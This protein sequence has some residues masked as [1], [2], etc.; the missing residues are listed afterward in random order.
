MIRD[1]EVI[2]ELDCKLK[3][4]GELGQF[5]AKFIDFL[6]VDFIPK[7][8]FEH[9]LF[10]PFAADVS[11]H[12]IEILADFFYLRGVLRTFSDCFEVFSIVFYVFSISSVIC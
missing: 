7:D 9:Y 2:L 8:F 1:L 4:A 5:S 10:K 11:I 12:F 3:G 6:D